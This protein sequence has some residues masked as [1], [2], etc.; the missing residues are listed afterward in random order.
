MPAIG[1]D[2]ER[3]LKTRCDVFCDV[4]RVALMEEQVEQYDLPENPGKRKDARAG[5]FIEKYGRLAQVE[6]DAL[7]PEVLQQ[8][9]TYALAEYL[10]MSTWNGIL[11]DEEGDR[12]F[13][14]DL[15]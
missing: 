9:F 3:D 1:E 14:R 6:V 13:I 11:E 12:Q 7:P 10:D 4:R 8:L 2:I 5:R 15:V